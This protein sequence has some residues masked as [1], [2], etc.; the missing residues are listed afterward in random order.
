M[1]LRRPLLLVASAAIALP[2]S[3][4]HCTAFLAPS[5]RS[6]SRP[7]T[8]S[9]TST[10][11]SSR[12]HAVLPTNGSS[13]EQ[14]DAPKTIEE[15]AALQWELYTR[16]QA[17]LDGEWWGTW[18]TYNYMGDL[19]DSSVVGWVIL[20]QLLL[21]LQEIFDDA[22]IIDLVFIFFFSFSI[23][24]RLSILLQTSIFQPNYDNNQ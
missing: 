6:F 23:L 19:E 18:M 1:A 4:I 3:N 22:H 2:S 13:S 5:S 17:V 8:P 15:D 20:H 7:L 14:P 12:R 21:S 10:S 24:Y 9:S 16:H 11:T